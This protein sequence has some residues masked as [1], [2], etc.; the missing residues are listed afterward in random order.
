MQLKSTDTAV[1]DGLLAERNQGI[2]IVVVLLVD[3]VANSRLVPFDSS[4]S[5]ATH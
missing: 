4:L 5:S 1:D 2:G 3:G